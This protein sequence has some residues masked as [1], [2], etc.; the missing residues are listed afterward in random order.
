MAAWGVL[1]AA[2]P[3][4]TRP[5]VEV[6]TS[7]VGPFYRIYDAAHGAP[8][9]E[10]LQRDYI[11][12]GSDGVRQFVPNRIL[13]GAALAQRIARDRP[14][15]DQARACLSVLP[16][17][18]A[19]LQGFFRRLAALDP[20]ATFP[21]VTI[22]IGRN[23]S[24]GTTGK[25]GVLIGLE[26]AC[27]SSWMQPDLTDR[28]YHLIAHEYGHVQQPE[29]LDGPGNSVLKQSLLEGVAE[30][31]A[32]L[33]SGQVSNVHLQ[34]WTRGHAQEIDW[35]FIVDADKTDLSDWLYN[36]PGTPDHPGDLGY[37]VG[38]RIAKAYYERAK[39]KRAALRTLLELRDPKAI[40]AQSG[41]TAHL[42]QAKVA[43]GR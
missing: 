24:G 2:S 22:L 27:R 31:I 34:R 3:A 43:P 40:L 35:R 39:D 19:R 10:T 9:G 16:Q 32:E 25:S 14:A 37:W 23:T 1:V 5:A 30:L 42:Q 38:Y 7:D 11:D 33:A 20:Q 12:G 28:L 29:A 36:G 15:Y 41:W 26:V 8:S 17:V 18:K 4:P 21:P 13:S 6:R